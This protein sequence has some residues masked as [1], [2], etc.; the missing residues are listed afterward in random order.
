[1]RPARSAH[2]R[3]YIDRIDMK[4]READRQDCALAD[5]DRPR[6]DSLRLLR[7]TARAPPLMYSEPAVQ[8][9]ERLARDDRPP[10]NARYDIVLSVCAGEDGAQ[11]DRGALARLTEGFG[12]GRKERFRWPVTTSEP[13]G[14]V[15][16]AQQ[17]R[18]RS[19]LLLSTR[20]L[21]RATGPQFN[22]SE[23]GGVSTARI[24]SRLKSLVQ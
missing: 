18:S 13:A 8:R 6:N 14:D 17:I 20:S 7:L 9:V 15:G 19:A 21:T 10:V 3:I 16:A 2:Q 12:L 24:I 23:S 4:S 22:I 1:M 5:S 11:V